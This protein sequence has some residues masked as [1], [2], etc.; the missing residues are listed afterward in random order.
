MQAV[1]SKEINVHKTAIV[2]A[3]ARLSPG[4]TIGAYAYVGPCV[5]LGQ[6]TVV[7]HHA[8][9]DGHT[10]IGE[11]NRIYPYAF[12]G[13]KTHDLKYKNGQTF[14]RIGHRNVFRE[15]TSIHTATGDGDRTIVG[16][17]NYFLA[18]A[19]LGHDCRVGHH[20]IVSAGAAIGGHVHL[21]DYVNVG[22]N[23]SI[24]QFCH[25]GTHAMLGAHSFLKK[26]LLPFFLAIGV[27]ATVQSFNQVGMKRSGFSVPEQREVKYLFKCFYQG[28]HNRSQAL[29][30]IRSLIPLPDTS[31]SMRKWI[32]IFEEFCG[33]SV[34]G[35][36]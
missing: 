4:V 27:P 16:D 33:R 18:F 9:V 26:D 7:D 28:P 30:K 14:L 15:Y 32:S 10:E 35:L 25:L 2:E 5:K 29:E 23:A 20:V 31:D 6:N 19:H 22:G 24:H 17:D 36:I 1:D 11:N 8:T 13:A 21:D 12:I 3:G 34:R